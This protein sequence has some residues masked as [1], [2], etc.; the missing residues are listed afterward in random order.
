[1]FRVTSLT[2]MDDRQLNKW[3]KRVVLLLVAGTV[4]FTGFYVLDRWRAATDADRG[5][6]A[7]PRWSRPS[8][9]TP[10][11]S[12]RAGQLADT[13]VAKGRYDEAIAQYNLILD[14]RQGGGA[15][16]VRPGRRLHG[17]RAVRPGREG[18]RG[19]SSRSPRAARWP[20]STRCS[21]PP[22]TASA[23]SR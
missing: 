2:T 3:I 4:L 18:L 1:M 5:P 17:P 23:R 19:A 6:P 9:T 21:R 11:T 8:A 13:Y 16:D 12:C 20:T 10:R 7:S 14:D 22:T 15:R